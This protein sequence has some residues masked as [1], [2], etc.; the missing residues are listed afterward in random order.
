V[1]F[2]RRTLLTSLG[3]VLPAM[4]AEA[5]TPRKR[6][7][8]PHRVAKAATHAKPHKLVRHRRLTAKPPV[9]QG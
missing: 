2:S 4:A 5:A 6:V 9:K 3:L 8:K 7:A 1:T